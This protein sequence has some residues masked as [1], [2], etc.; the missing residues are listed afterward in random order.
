MND[1][2]K[3]KPGRPKKLPSGSERIGVMLSPEQ[4]EKAGKIGNGNVSDGIRRALD[5][6]DILERVK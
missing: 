2:N 1:E 4:I 6:M 5:T 3:R